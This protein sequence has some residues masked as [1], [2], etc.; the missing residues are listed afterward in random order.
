[1]QFQEVPEMLKKL[2]EKWIKLP[3]PPTPEKCFYGGTLKRSM[4]DGNQW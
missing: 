2:Q 4:V 3:F 1:M